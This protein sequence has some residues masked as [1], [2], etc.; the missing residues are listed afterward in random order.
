MELDVVEKLYQLEALC[1]QNGSVDDLPQAISEYAAIIERN[2]QGSDRS[3]FAKLDLYTASLRDTVRGLGKTGL[4]GVTTRENYNKKVLDIIGKHL[5][6]GNESKLLPI[7]Y[8]LYQNYLNPFNPVTTIQYDVPKTSQV[9]L[10]IYDI[11]GREVTTLVNE[12]KV[13]GK[14]TTQ[15]NASRLSSGVYFCRITAGKFNAVK[16]MMLIK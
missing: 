11:L 9:S 15:F 7:E 6:K 13:Q 12:E 1:Y 4:Y 14:Y 16:K 3:D 8:K 2:P 10:K 5:K